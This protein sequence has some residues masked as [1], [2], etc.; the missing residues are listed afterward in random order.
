MLR[1]QAGILQP[2]FSDSNRLEFVDGDTA[3]EGREQACE[4]LEAFVSKALVDVSNRLKTQLQF[5]RQIADL[6][7]RRISVPLQTLSINGLTIG[8]EAQV[9]Y[10]PPEPPWS[11]RISDPEIR[12]SLKVPGT[13]I[14]KSGNVT[15]GR[16]F[17]DSVCR[18]IAE[19]EEDARYRESVAQSKRRQIEEL[20]G[21]QDRPFTHAQELADSRN[22]LETVKAELER[23]SNA[24]KIGAGQHSSEEPGNRVGNEPFPSSSAA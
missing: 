14:W 13:D 10:R 19:L 12:Y 4:L 23:S 9:Q 1:E 11:E 20:T 3:A 21:L 6:R 2:V 7:E 15:T 16:G 5:D 17:L 22:R 8:A 18:K 24:T